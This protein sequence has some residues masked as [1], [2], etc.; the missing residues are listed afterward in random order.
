MP[1]V[2]HV[3]P[4]P[5]R[6]GPDAYLT[7]GEGDLKQIMDEEFQG[8]YRWWN[9]AE[10][11]DL[12]QWTR[13]DNVKHPGDP[14]RFVG[15]DNGFAGPGLYDK[16]NAFAAA[17]SPGLAAQIAEP[18]RGLRPTTCAETYVNDYFAKPLAERKELAERTGRAVDLLKQ[19]PGA[20]ADAWALQHATAI[21]QM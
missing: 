4:A 13:A 14:L 21:H 10:S 20:D 2:A 15:D 8:T 12:L 16:V 17:S 9:N 6:C 18:Y 5:H 7:H 11:R 3:T 19:H 1:A